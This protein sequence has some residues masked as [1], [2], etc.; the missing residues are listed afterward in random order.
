MSIHFNHINRVE[1][2]FFSILEHCKYYNET[3]QNNRKIDAAQK[4]LF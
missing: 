2:V 1:I 4:K 3:F